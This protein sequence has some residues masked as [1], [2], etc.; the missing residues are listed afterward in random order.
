MHSIHANMLSLREFVEVFDSLNPWH[1]AQLTN[2]PL[3][4][5][6]VSA[7]LAH[8]SDVVYEKRFKGIERISRTMVASAIKRAE[9]KYR[10]YTRYNP[11]PVYQED[12]PV[13]W[14]LPR[15]NLKGCVLG[16][17]Y[18]PLGYIRA[19]GKEV[20]TSIGTAS[21]NILDAIPDTSGGYSETVTASIVAAGATGLTAS[22]VAVFF[23]DTDYSGEQ[24]DWEIRPVLITIDDT[25]PD[26]PVINLEAPLYMF[27]RPELYQETAPNTIDAT[28]ALNFVGSVE[29]FRRT[30]DET[31]QG[32]ITHSS[33][34]NILTSTPCFTIVDR[35]AGLVRVEQSDV[36]GQ[37]ACTCS[38]TEDALEVTINYVSG[39]K[40][41]ANGWMDHDHA[42]ILA[43]L[44][45][46]LMECLP[47]GCSCSDP[48][49]S[50]LHR[51]ASVPQQESRA[52]NITFLTSQEFIKSKFG[53]TEGGVEAFLFARD[54][55][56]IR[57]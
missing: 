28:S 21:I 30:Y 37:P 32:L 36:V 23:L 12:A 40:R 13:L 25:D 43:R 46:S 42:D 41:Q 48:D 55:K 47:C 27:V 7:S 10:D 29:F 49:K 51:W 31:D 24:E 18:T 39:H 22:E 5:D 34:C 19:I 3:R 35:E 53:A 6:V 44:A 57:V 20:L 15:F 1:F 17:G 14:R 11:A 38:T 2:V 4:T 50:P 9:A 8:C 56:V 33:G 52:G 54:R 16:V 45:A 26:N